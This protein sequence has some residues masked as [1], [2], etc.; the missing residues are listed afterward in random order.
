LALAAAP[1][2]QAAPV[3]SGDP[4]NECVWNA[5]YD[6]APFMQEHHASMLRLVVTSVHP[7][8]VVEYGRMV[9]P[10]YA[11]AL[12]G[13]MACVRNAQAEG[14]PVLI[15]FEFPNVWL[16]SQVAGWFGQVLP[17]F[18]HL[19]GVGIGNEQDLQYSRYPETPPSFVNVSAGRDITTYTVN[20]VVSYE[21]RKVKKWV[22]VRRH[23][24]TR[25]IR[26]V[27][28]KRVRHVS[29][30]VDPQTTTVQTTTTQRASTSE[31]YR[32]DYDAAEPVVAWL[33][34][35]ARISFGN[36]FPFGQQFIL[37]AWAFG[38]RPAGVDAIGISG[39]WLGG[40]P[41]LAAFAQ[42]EGLPLWVPED[43]PNG[44][45]GDGSTA[46]PPDWQARWNAAV[47]QAPN[48]T[49]DDFYS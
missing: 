37:D 38:G 42:L 28:T 39:Y 15:S 8:G 25:R 27:V 26:R 29:Y 36:A 4:Q 2:A 32:L 13:E 20:E 14:Y 45:G 33:E 49:L 22:R 31:Q 34:P 23:K 16:P 35:A 47:A 12:A 3:M 44:P 43:N 19:W 40:I 11:Q 1:V 7:D 10:P 46:Q 5:N 9:I 17:D 48:W 21:S 6:P 18:P 41:S 30:Q 24:H